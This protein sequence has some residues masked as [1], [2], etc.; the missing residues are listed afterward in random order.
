MHSMIDFDMSFFYIK[1]IAFILIG[2]LSAYKK[3]EKVD[4]NKVVQITAMVT[5]IIFCLTSF[6]GNSTLSIAKSLTKD[7]REMKNF[8]LANKLAPYSA[9]IKSRELA[10]LDIRRN[11]MDR[12]IQIYEDLLKYEKQY[13]NITAYDKLSKYARIHL[14]KGKIEEAEKLLKQASDILDDRRN[15]FPINLYRYTRNVHI[16][17][18][19]IED[20]KE[21]NDNEIVSRYIEK[22]KQEAITIIEEAKKNITDYKITT[23]SKEYFE[24][25][26]RRLR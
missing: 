9:E 11:N 24:N 23:M 10:Y 18:G 20:L 22:S 8:E 5:L 4:N 6:I 25:A 19:H 26:T 1:L 21:W 13:D 7:K 14:K 16:I 3:E 2:M 17:V 15:N 12:I